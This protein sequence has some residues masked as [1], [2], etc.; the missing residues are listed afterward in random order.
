MSTGFRQRGRAIAAFLVLSLLLTLVPAIAAGTPSARG[1]EPASALDCRPL[2]EQ[3]PELLPSGSPAPPPPAGEPASELVPVRIGFVPVSIYAPIFVAYELGYF[4]EFG[5]DVTLEPTS[6]GSDLISLTASGNLDISA[7]G[8]GPAFWNA[9]DLDLPVTVI[10]PGHQ[11]GSP[12]ATPLMISRAACE[13]GAISSVAD[14]AG[15]RV[16]VNA[17]GGTEF[18]LG[19]ALATAG[20]TIDD[21]DEQFLPFPDA[22]AALESGALDAA[23]IGEPLAT[24]AELD[25]LAV[26]LL[27]DFPVQDIQPTA[28]I[29]NDD[30]LATNPEAATGF[31]AGYLKAARALSGDGSKD[32]GVLAIIQEYTG[33]PPELAARA[34]PPVYQPD[35]RI[36]VASLGQLQ[37]FFRERGQLEYDTDIDPAT[38]ADLR[39]VEGALALIGPSTPAATLVAHARVQS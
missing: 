34:I 32:P 30:F 25:G 12:V 27:P 7:A 26:R 38:I 4:A 28:I 37:S 8:A 11:E 21:V 19:Q 5:L 15:K 22:V 3:R 14:L 39:Y 20:L 31:V 29:G 9:I 23:M 24:Q 2:T 10:A 13:S 6:G 1:Q 17:P 35:G 18:W 16:S 33:V 36:D